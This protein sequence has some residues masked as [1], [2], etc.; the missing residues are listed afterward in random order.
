VN[1]MNDFRWEN[2]EKIDLTDEEQSELEARQKA[3]AD[4]IATEGY[5]YSR[6]DAYGAIADQL[7]MIFWDGVNDTTVWADHVAA[8]KAAYPKPAG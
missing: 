5:K 1:D 7:D 4:R 2:G 8:V 3:K 6:A